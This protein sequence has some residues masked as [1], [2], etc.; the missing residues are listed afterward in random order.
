MPTD[1]LKVCAIAVMAKASIAGRAKTRLVPPLTMEEAALLNTA[2][3]QD[4]SQN[5]IASLKYVEIQ[6]AMAFAPAGTE[7]FFR[8]ALPDG[9]ELVETVAPN[10]GDCLFHALRTLL[11]SGFGSVCL[12]NSDSPTLPVAYLVTAATVLAA[13]GD[14]VVLG[15]STD[16]GYYLIGMKQPHRRMFDNVDWSTERVFEQSL[17]RAAELGLPVVTLPAWYDID[18]AET[19]RTLIRELRH[20]QRFRRVGTMATAAAASRHLLQELLTT[21]DLGVRLGLEPN[22][23]ANVNPA[24]INS[25]SAG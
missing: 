3:L 14:R 25:A 24:H 2:F 7:A 13:P 8:N 21:T 15:P 11:A 18:E 12:L 6:P 10:F 20:G 19:V 17:A 1:R 23:S 5:L 16:G 4:I 22:A 9:I